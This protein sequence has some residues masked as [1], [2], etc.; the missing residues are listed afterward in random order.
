LPEGVLFVPPVRSFVRAWSGRPRLP[1][2]FAAAH[3]LD[4]AIAANV[5]AVL[6]VVV[7]GGFDIGIWSASGAAKPALI[8]MRAPATGR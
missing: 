8:L 7:F 3:L 4:I 5:L 6:A 1:L 2:D